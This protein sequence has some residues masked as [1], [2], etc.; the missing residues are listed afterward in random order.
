MFCKQCVLLTSVKCSIN[1]Q[2]PWGN[3]TLSAS[4]LKINIPFPPPPFFTKD[5]RQSRNN[6]QNICTHGFCFKCFS[7][8]DKCTE[9]GTFFLQDYLKKKVSTLFKFKSKK[10][11]HTSLSKK[12]EDKSLSKVICAWWNDKITWPISFSLIPDIQN[13]MDQHHQSKLYVGYRYWLFLT[14]LYTFLHKNQ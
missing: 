2:A 13:T 1:C 12:S 4:Y 9:L 14:F 10:K 8:R 3:P 5:A 11:L 7:K 6:D